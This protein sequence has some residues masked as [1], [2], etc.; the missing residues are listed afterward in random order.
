MV[1]LVWEDSLVRKWFLSK[2]INLIGVSLT[3]YLNVQ[4]IYETLYLA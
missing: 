1:K 4:D 2:G 3:P